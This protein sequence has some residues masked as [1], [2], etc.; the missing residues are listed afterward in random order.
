MITFNEWMKT[1]EGAANWDKNP[2]DKAADSRFA[3]SKN[4]QRV[5]ADAEERAFKRRDTTVGD[6]D[7][8]GDEAGG[9]FP[10]YKRKPFM[11]KK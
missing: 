6:E 4:R 1:Q 7:E 10:K 5:H 9:N 3:L 2:T 11:K 8:N